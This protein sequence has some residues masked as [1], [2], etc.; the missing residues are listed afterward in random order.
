[1]EIHFSDMRS[2]KPL[3][4]LASGFFVTTLLTVIFGYWAVTQLHSSYQVIETFLVHPFAVSNATVELKSDVTLIRLDMLR[5]TNANQAK[6]RNNIR[7]EIERADNDAKEQLRIIHAQFLGDLSKVGA[8]EKILNNWRLLRGEIFTQINSGQTQRAEYSASTKG[9]VFF[10][11]AVSLI[12]YIDGFAHNKALELENDGHHQVESAIYLMWGLLGGIV[13][14]SGAMGLYVFRELYIHACRLERNAY[15][16]TLTKFPNR[17]YLNV[18]SELEFNRIKRYGGTMSMLI[19]DIDHFK[20]VN[21]EHGH[22]AGDE[23][24]RLLARVLHNT[25]RG[26]DMAC[27][28]GGEEFVVLMPQMNA[29]SARELGNRIQTTFSSQSVIWHGA[30]I[31]CT[32]SIGI[33]EYDKQLNI[34]E[35]FEEADIALYHAKNAGRNRIEQFSKATSEEN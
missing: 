28:W 35:L 14:L 25:C 1:M 30:E 9:E 32:I 23:V 34:R 8:L 27:R 10:R 4:I 15:L 21:D 3:L 13:F 18:F 11:Q 26:S 6:D 20:K 16:D 22:P 24:L 33:A 5:V 7:G 17:H 12:G 31:K 29:L 2:K 19:I